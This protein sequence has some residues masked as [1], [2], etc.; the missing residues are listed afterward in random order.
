MNP[1]NLTTDDNKHYTAWHVEMSM[2]VEN[3][4]G[5][6]IPVKGGDWIISSDIME[7]T[8]ESDILFRKHFIGSGPQKET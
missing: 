5:Q 8:V 1:M 7:I 3:H 2:T 4:L 6:L